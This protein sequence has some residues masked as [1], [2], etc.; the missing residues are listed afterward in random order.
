MP[1][2]VVISETTYA[3]TDL[4]IV[5]KGLGR[6]NLEPVVAPVNPGIDIVT[7]PVSVKVRVVH[8]SPRRSPTRWLWQKLFPTPKSQK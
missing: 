4:E 8:L 5:S 7:P 1:K 3:L 2:E 6:G